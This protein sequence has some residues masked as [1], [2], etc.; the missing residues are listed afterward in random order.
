MCLPVKTNHGCSSRKSYSI[1]YSMP[2]ITRQESFRHAIWISAPVRGSGMMI[3]GIFSTVNSP[4]LNF[5]FPRTSTYRC[6]FTLSGSKISLASYCPSGAALC[7]LPGELWACLLHGA[8]RERR[9][10]QSLAHLVTFRESTWSVDF[11]RQALGKC[12]ELD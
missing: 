1:G 4:A 8:Q 6:R 12:V 7:Q 11:L 9:E 3:C 10:E 5:Q 2:L